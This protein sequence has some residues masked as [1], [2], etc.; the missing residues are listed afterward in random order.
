MINRHADDLLHAG[1]LDRLLHLV[2]A[3]EF[4]LV[5]AHRLGPARLRVGARQGV[6]HRIAKRCEEPGCNQVAMR[7]QSGAR[8][9]ENLLVAQLAGRQFLFLECGLQLVQPARHPLAR[10][11]ERLL[12]AGVKGLEMGSHAG[13]FLQSKGQGEVMEPL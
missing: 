10:L 4:E 2:V 8:F 12:E 11:G 13:E 9:D 6:A 7:L 5:K 3:H 1:Q